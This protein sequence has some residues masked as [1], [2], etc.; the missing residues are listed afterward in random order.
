MIG[1]Y[2]G[3]FDPVHYGHLRTA[4]EIREKLALEAL[5]FVPCKK[6]V[7]RGEPSVSAEKRLELLQLAIADVPELAVDCCELEREGPSFMVDTLRHV[8][9]EIG[10]SQPLVLVVGMDAFLGLPSWSRWI[11]LFELAHIAVMMRPGWQCDVSPELAEQINERI[12]GEL[13]ELSSVKAGKVCFVEVTQLEISATEIRNL[14]KT[15]R[16]PRYLLPDA[17]RESIIK[18]NLYR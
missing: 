18:E 5:R 9:K 8:R 7:H 14:A 17:V 4:L 1:I 11:E 15:G 2:G 13:G 6:P 10:E 3:T 16:D 12:A